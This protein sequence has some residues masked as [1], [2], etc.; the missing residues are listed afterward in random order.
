MPLIR[1]TI[2]QF[3]NGVSQQ[4]PNLRRES[5]VEAQLNCLSSIAE[6]IIPRSQTE[7]LALIE[8]ASLGNVFVHTINRDTEE[9]F[10]V[11]IGDEEIRVFD[12]EG[13][14]MTVTYPAGTTYLESDD[15]KQ[16]FRAYTVKDYTFIVNTNVITANTTRTPDTLDGTVQT[17]ARLNDVASAAAVGTIY[18]IEG[19]DGT[20]FD[21]Y[22]V[23]KTVESGTSGGDV[24]TETFDPTLAVLGLDEDTMPHQLVRTGPT[25]FE[26]QSITWADITCGDAVTNPLPSFVGKT[27]SDLFVYRNRFGFLSG[28][29]TILSESGAANFFNFFRTTVTQLLDSDPIDVSANNTRVADLQYAVPFTDSMLLFSEQTQYEFGSDDLLTPSTVEIKPTTEF[30]ASMKCR[31]VL[32]GRNI[33]FPV[34]RTEFTGIR[35]YFVDLDN[36]GNDAADITKHVPRYVPANVFKIIPSS[37]EDMLFILSSDEPDSIYIYQWFWAQTSGGLDK[38]QSSWHKWTLT[39]DAIILNADLID[40]TLILIVEREGSTFIESVDL[41][42]RNNDEGLMFPVRLDRRV[43]VQ[44]VYDGVTGFTTWTVPY[45]TD[46]PLALV[47][48]GAWAIN[49]GIQILN[50]SQPTSTTITAFG[51]HTD[52]KC[53]I[54]VEFPKSITLSPIYVREAGSSGGSISRLGGRLQLRNIKFFYNDTSLF[55][56]SVTPLARDTVTRQFTPVIGSSELVIGQIVPQ[57]GVFSVPVISKADT[58]TITIHSNSYLPFAITSAEWEGYFHSNA[59]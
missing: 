10:I 8:A 36:R 11:V 59:R 23:E 45:E 40:N 28:D 32:A 21:S 31:P 4:A 20:G 43:E 16:D 55:N 50:M 48:N 9:R 34:E 53:F 37:N 42:P 13:A 41:T 30:V 25:T 54:G 38:L 51:D 49:A 18:K 17:F 52:D 26:F 56:V 24:W 14:E 33:Y 46:Q 35:E 12:L 15:P 39:D 6:G 19:D 27:I 5:Q 29:N 7:H 1:D 47:R 22:Y 3:F 44:G 58:T 57:E 2:P